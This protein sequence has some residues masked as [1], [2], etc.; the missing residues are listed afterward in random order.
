MSQDLF[1]WLK[2]LNHEASKDVEQEHS[3]VIYPNS[4]F[5]IL[6]PSGLRF[7]GVSLSISCFCLS[8]PRCQLRLEGIPNKH[9][10]HLMLS[11]SFWHVSSYKYIGILSHS[12]DFNLWLHS[13]YPRD[14][15]LQPPHVVADSRRVP[16]RASAP[17]H[18]TAPGGRRSHPTAVC[19]DTTN[20]LATVVCWTDYWLRYSAFI[21]FH[22]KQYFK[23]II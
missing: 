1:H 8:C 22:I 11:K 6:L 13:F 21:R 3:K 17:T 10:P 19:A 4:I 7:R 14:R 23:Y 5:S 18:P 2:W 9:S 20:N 16:G 12:F 15:P